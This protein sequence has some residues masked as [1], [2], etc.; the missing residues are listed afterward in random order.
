MKL[1]E[2]NVAT[3]IAEMISHT[4]DVTRHTSNDFCEIKLEKVN[5]ELRVGCRSSVDDVD[6]KF[7]EVIKL[8]IDSRSL[9][10]VVYLACEAIILF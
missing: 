9:D 5:H 8:P 6:E 10:V 4:D 3:N 1:W 2:A 7:Q